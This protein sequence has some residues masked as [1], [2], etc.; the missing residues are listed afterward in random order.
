MTCCVLLIALCQ[1]QLVQIT[2]PSK[3]FKQP[4]IHSKDVGVKKKFGKDRRLFNVCRGPD[5]SNTREQPRTELNKLL[6]VMSFN[7][8]RSSEQ[9][10]IRCWC[11]LKAAYGN[12]NTRS[13][14][15]IM[16]TCTGYQRCTR[17]VSF[18]LSLKRNLKAFFYECPEP[19]DQKPKCNQ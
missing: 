15:T 14:S 2:A 13:N 4:N 6:K 16:Y 1:Y 17:S 10:S 7:L 3:D 12:K 9:A 18:C 5:S 19:R 8:L 11:R